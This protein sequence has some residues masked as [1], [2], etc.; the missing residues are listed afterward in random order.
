MK[1]KIYYQD[2]Y[3]NSRILNSAELKLDEK[4]AAL[5]AE[6]EFDV[7]TKAEFCRE[8]FRELN[9]G[10]MIS[11]KVFQ[12]N[13]QSQHFDGKHTSMSVG[14]YVK[15]EDNEIWMIAPI[16]YRQFPPALPKSITNK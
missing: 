10:K 11:S 9:I 1:A 4:P 7:T 12:K 13:V 8:A 5:M 14:D 3:L 15:F 2:F 16:G 6:L